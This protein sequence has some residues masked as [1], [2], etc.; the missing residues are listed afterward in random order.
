MAITMQ[1]V[2]HLA[3]LSKLALSEEEK[4]RLTGEMQSI[5]S[6]ADKLS[7]LETAADPTMFAADGQNVFRRDEIKPSLPTAAIL[8]NAP[9]KDMECFVVP[10]TVE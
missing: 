5:L 1:E 10:K 9:E 8:Q 2:E 7:T 6:F 3:K 4:E